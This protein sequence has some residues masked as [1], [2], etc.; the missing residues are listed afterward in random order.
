[1]SDNTQHKPRLR[2]GMFVHLDLPWMAHPFFTSSFK[3]RTRKQLE[4][5]LQLDLGRVRVDLARSDPEPEDLPADD[6]PEGDGDAEAR[7]QL[8]ADLEA[9]LWEEKN[10][11]I[12]VLKERRKRLNLCAKR[13][14]QSVVLARKLMS[15]LRSAPAQAA[16]EADALVSQMVDDL[17]A[18]HEATV[19]LVN[20]KSQDENTYHHA[21]N[22][23]A[24]A[25]VL[26][27]KLKLDRE[28]LRLLGLGALFHDLGLQ[29]IPSQ[30]LHKKGDWNKPERALYE[31]HPR[32]GVEIAQTIGTLPDAVIEVIGQ[33]HEHLDGSGYPDGLSG[34]ALGALTRIV[35]VVNR[36]DNLCNGTYSGRGLSPHQAVSS[37]YTKDRARYDPRV[38]TTLITNLG[39]YPPGTVVRLEDER[40]AV[41]ISI[42]PDDLLRPNVL[43]YSPEIPS[44]QAL[45]LDL[46]EEEGAIRESLHQ[47]ELTEDII[48][49]LNLSDKLSYYVQSSPAK[50]R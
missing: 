5:L 44:D 15:H 37:M 47:S 10:A 7:D 49:Y 20:L 33:H 16:E 31:Q 1:M 18:D 17:T 22:V 45:I 32:Y 27:R 34:K 26:G 3:I 42:N 23:M 43:V 39:V 8:R 11:R 46:S 36:Y 6:E 19:Q 24:L 30:I 4:T 35:S 12:R 29:R 21:I 38:L 50:G 41:V 48:E 14:R 25:L 13:Y 40:V 28:N 2:I 9:S